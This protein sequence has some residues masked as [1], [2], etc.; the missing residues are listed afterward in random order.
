MAPA[1]FP[2]AGTLESSLKDSGPWRWDSLS[3]LATSPAGT[4]VQFQVAAS[5]SPSGPFNFVGPDGTANTYFTTSGASLAQLGSARYVKYKAFLRTG[6][7][8]LTPTLHEVTLC[9]FVPDVIFADGFE[10]GDT[11][12]WS[13]SWP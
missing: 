8:S 11:S 7:G 9:Q 2:A 5:N 10:S 1:N 4:S 3:W 13:F 6:A 12:A